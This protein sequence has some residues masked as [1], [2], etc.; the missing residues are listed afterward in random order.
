MSL[1][2]VLLEV[3]T[4][5]AI[6]LFAVIARFVGL[7]GELYL[8]FFFYVV[9]GSVLWPLLF[10]ALERYIPL[11]PDPAARGMV[12]GAVLWVPFVI[13]GRGDLTGPILVV[14]A[15]FTLL[16]HLAYGFSMGAVYEHLRNASVTS[17]TAGGENRV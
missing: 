5:S 1:L 15:S 3:Q 7:P 9:A 11:G 2:F 13:V 8:G 16:A 10:L 6:G 14:Y 17:T 12:F 4:R